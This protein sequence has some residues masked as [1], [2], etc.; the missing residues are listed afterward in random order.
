MSVFRLASL[1]AAVCSVLMMAGLAW[2]RSS[3]AGTG[4]TDIYG[5]DFQKVFP[6]QNASI[7]GRWSPVTT[8]STDIYTT[9]F[10]EVFA[11]DPATSH[12]ASSAAPVRGSTD[13]YSTNFQAAFL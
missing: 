5:T 9:D 11:S 10:Q 1:R 7:R 6:T 2:A 12:K 3:A 4:S 8:G 13:I